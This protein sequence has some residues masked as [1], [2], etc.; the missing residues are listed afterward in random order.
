MEQRELDMSPVLSLCKLIKLLK[1]LHAFLPRI[2]N[3]GLLALQCCLPTRCLAEAQLKQ[4]P[5]LAAKL[6]SACDSFNCSACS[7]HICIAS[8]SMM[9]V[10]MK[11]CAIHAL[12]LFLLTCSGAHDL[13][14]PGDGQVQPAV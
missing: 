1:K 2:R 10:G 7:C 11:A 6:K 13:H 5:M 14:S 8:T 9:L 4:M 12:T 3:G